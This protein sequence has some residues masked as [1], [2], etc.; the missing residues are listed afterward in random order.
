MNKQDEIKFLIKTYGIKRSWIAEQ[1]GIKT[2]TLQFLLEDP[3]KFDDEL[4]ESIKKLI[5]TYQYELKL[6]EEERATDSLSLFEDHELKKG[7]GER[8]RMFARRK[9]GKLKT[10]AEAM[11]IS[12]QQ[13]QQYVSG[14]REP[15]ARILVKFLRL[16]C[17]INWLLGGSESLESYRIY[18]LET[19]IRKLQSSLSQIEAIANGTIHQHKEHPP[20]S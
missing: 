19:E 18:K 17:D 9:Y 4:Y 20:K 8:I 16:G 7:I 10:M 2:Q 15:G 12:P 5:N 14:N 1:L 13:L 11:K 3:E 6:Y